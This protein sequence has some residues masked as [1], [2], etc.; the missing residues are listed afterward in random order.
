[1][2]LQ[3]IKSDGTAVKTPPDIILIKLLGVDFIRLRPHVKIESSLVS[4]YDFL[5]QSTKG[6][7]ALP[8]NHCIITLR[9]LRNN[10]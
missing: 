3:F 9:F 1:M 7:A 8:V 5:L 4:F 2:Y 6:L 10:I